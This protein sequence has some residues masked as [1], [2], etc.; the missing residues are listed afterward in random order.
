MNYLEFKNRFFE[1][2]C[3]NINQVYAWQPKFDRNNLTRWLKKRLLV[4]LR[5]GYYAFPEYKQE[6]DYSF[7]KTKCGINNL[8]ELKIKVTEMLAQ[9]DLKSKIKDFNH[10]LFNKNNSRKILYIEEFIKRL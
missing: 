7:L 6:A 10:L 8:T 3:F 1:L 4:H 5:Q 9:V 2:G